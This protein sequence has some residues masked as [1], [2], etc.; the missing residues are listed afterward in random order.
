MSRVAFIGAGPGDPEL[1]TLKAARR[2]E[3]ADLVLYA[4]SLVPREILTMAREDARVVDSA[5]LSLEQTHALIMETVRAGGFVARVH[6]GDPGLYGAVR[7]QAA[8]LEAEG[9]E[10]EIVPGVTAAFDVAAR[11][12]VSLT[13]P[14]VAQSV[15]LTRLDGKTPVPDGQRLRR[16]AATGASLAVYLSAAKPE[17]LREELLAAGLPPETPVVVAHKAGWPGGEVRRTT[18]AGIEETARDMKISR[19][20]LFLV[21]PGELAG[22][23]RSRLYDPAHGHCFRPKVPG[24]AENDG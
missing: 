21:L 8:L 10:Y 9:V 11:A 18:I 24:D 4:G 2:I 3:R 12:R 22:E 15:V 19:Q 13:V 14:G 5:P 16:F 23:A 7:E 1:L 20:T 6:T 17:T